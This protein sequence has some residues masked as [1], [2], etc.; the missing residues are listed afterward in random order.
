VP[1][2]GVFAAVFDQRDHVLCVKRAYGNQQWT[3]PGGRVEP[4]EAP[5]DAL[6]RE[7]EE[8]TG[9]IIRITHLIGVYATPAKD[10]IV[11]CFRAEPLRRGCWQANEEIAQAEFFAQE[12]LPHPLSPKARVRIHDAFEGRAGV[13]RVFAMEGGKLR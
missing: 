8:E 9:F 3:L 7:V 12:A 6:V 13:L 2:M 11:L 4:G 5:D 1:T 10:D